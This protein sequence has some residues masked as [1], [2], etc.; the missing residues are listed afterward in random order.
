MVRVRQ[1]G[2]QDRGEDGIWLQE[3]FEVV[4]VGDCRKVSEGKSMNFFFMFLYV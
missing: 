1:K 4:E 3:E 2:E